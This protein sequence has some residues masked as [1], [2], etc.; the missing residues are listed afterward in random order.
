MTG[1]HTSGSQ[2]P[3]QPSTAPPLPLATA[4]AANVYT[5]VPANTWRA[6]PEVR[7]SM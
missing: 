1:A 3:G 7:P 5:S 4:E 2:A 6:E